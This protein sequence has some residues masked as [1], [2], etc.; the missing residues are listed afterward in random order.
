MKK[1]LSGWLVA[2]LLA[3]FVSSAVAQSATAYSSSAVGVIKKTIPVGKRVLMSIPLDQATDV[4]QGFKITDIPAFES[5]PNGTEVSFWVLGENGTYSWLTQS[6][7]KGKWQG[8]VTNVLI[9]VGD[10]FFVKNG[11]T[12]PIEFIVSGEVPSDSTL[13][14]PLP[15]DNRVLVGNPYPVPMAFTDL[16]F[17]DNLAN[18]SQVSLWDPDTLWYTQSKKKGKWQGDITN[19][20]FEAGEGFFLKSDSQD[21]VWQEARPYTWPN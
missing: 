21:A 4:G 2:A 19:H 17:A 15:A 7:K 5:A 6:K 9:N 3:A 16:G 11:T 10:A 13:S 18:G 20:V 14:V 8:E 12:S 1:R